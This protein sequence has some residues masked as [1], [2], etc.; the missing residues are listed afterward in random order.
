[1]SARDVRTGRNPDF[2]AGIGIIKREL[3]AACLIP[4]GAIPIPALANVKVCLRGLGVEMRC[5][6]DDDHNRERNSEIL[7]SKYHFIAPSD[8]MS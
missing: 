4:C 6:H 8:K 1:L 2:V 7:A 5:R 3:N